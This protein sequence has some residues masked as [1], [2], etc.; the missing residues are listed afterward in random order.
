MKR[1]VALSALVIATAVSQSF[2]RFTYSVLYIEMRDDFGLSNTMAGGIGSLNLVGY[3]T[4]SL[5][6][7]LTI[8][9]LGLIKTVKYGLAGVVLGLLL[10]SWAPDRKSVV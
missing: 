9:K 5:A 7:A 1:L 2:G 8:R 10:L 6:V 3:L 4:G